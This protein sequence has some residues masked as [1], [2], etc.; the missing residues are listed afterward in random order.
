ME[1]RY[2]V[3]NYDIYKAVKVKMALSNSMKCTI[4]YFISLEILILQR[5]KYNEDIIDHV[6]K[7]I[8]IYQHTF[9]HM[10]T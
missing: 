1:N 10:Y 6:S 2:V 7:V 5:K 9:E 8:F 3:I 4:F